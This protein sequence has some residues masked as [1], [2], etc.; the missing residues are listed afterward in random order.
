MPYL[1]RTWNEKD[2]KTKSNEIWGEK[3]VNEFMEWAETINIILSHFNTHSKQHTYVR[4]SIQPKRQIILPNDIVKPQSKTT[5]VLVQWAPKEL[6]LVA[7]HP[8]IDIWNQHHEL[9]HNKADLVT[10]EA[11]YPICQQQRLIMS[12]SGMK[13]SLKETN[14]SS[15]GKLITLKLSILGCL[16]GSVS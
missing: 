9:H 16:S 13:P 12:N 11:E 7:K 4:D 6:V 3:P 1:F 14:K 5:S 8:S 15:G 2:K 10:L